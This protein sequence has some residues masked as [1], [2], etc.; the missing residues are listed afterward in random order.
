MAHCPIA[1]LRSQI[2][3]RTLTNCAEKCSHSTAEPE[4]LWEAC[5]ALAGT[6]ELGCRKG[7]HHSLTRVTH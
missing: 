5:W 3:V 6:W 7:A 4:A 1:Q 2:L